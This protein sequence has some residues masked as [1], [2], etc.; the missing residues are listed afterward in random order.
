M[1]KDK[2]PPTSW[3]ITGEKLSPIRQNFRQ[4]DSFTQKS[5]K[6]KQFPALVATSAPA[7][8]NESDGF[9]IR[10]NYNQEMIR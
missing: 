2:N 3:Q 4:S 10:Q 8:Q 9:K 5:I 1:N 7:S 6:I